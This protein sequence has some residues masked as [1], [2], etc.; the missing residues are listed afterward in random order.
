MGEDKRIVHKAY[1]SGRWFSA[2][3][4]ALVSEVKGYIDR[5]EMPRTLGRILGAIAPHAGYQYSGGVA[6][7]TFRALRD[8]AEAGQAP[9][10]IVILGFS[11]QGGFSG[12]AI[13][14]GDAIA[15]PVGESE[16]DVA[17]GDILT[18]AS[19]RIR[20]DR[21][22]H[23]GEHSAENEIPF[24]QVALPNAKLVVGLIGDHDAA[25]IDAL[26]SALH[27]LSVRRK[28]VVVASTDL[29]HDADYD[30][31]SRVDKQTLAMITALDARGLAHAWSP[32]SQVCCGIAPVLTLLKYMILHQVECGSLLTYC[33]SGDDHPESRGDWVVGYGSVVFSRE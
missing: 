23:Q 17:A 18:S 27:Q 6:G 22:P 24:A 13:L 15:T 28:I 29:L 16:L 14:D 10:T 5:A 20:F 33:N 12:T 32:S 8:S 7:H 30:R 4:A 2:E 1:G 3:H 21:R 25:T 9:E 26:A 31:V 11:H 19:A